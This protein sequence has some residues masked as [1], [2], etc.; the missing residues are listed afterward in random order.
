[1]SFKPELLAPAGNIESFFAAVENGAD[2]VYLG[3]K[4]FS[5]RAS[6]SNFTMSELATIVPFARKRGVRV[7]VAVNNQI[8]SGELAELITTIDRLARIHPD[9]LIVSD[10]AIFHLAR[11]HYPDLR[12]HASTLAFAHNSAGV[13]TLMGMG[14]SRVVTARELS[15][16]EIEKIY[17]NTGAELEIFIHGALCYS[18]SGLCL[19][20]SY[21]GGRSGLR[22]ECVQPCR[23]KFH[24]GSKGGFFLSCGDL[25][26]LPLV[27]RLKR[28]H[29]AA[30]KIEGRMKPASWV[31]GVVRAYRMVLDA[32][33]AEEEKRALSEAR[34]LL[35][36]NPS[37]RLS[38]GRLGNLGAA[39]ILSPSR[40]GSNG[41]W[42][43]T[44]K[45]VYENRVLLD[46]RSPVSKGDRLRPESSAG[47]EEEA[48]TVLQLFDKSGGAIEFSKAGTAA[49]LACPK[50]LKAGERLFKLGSKTEPAAAIWKRIKEQVPSAMAIK[51]APAIREIIGEYEKPEESGARAQEALTVKIDSPGDLVE[52]LQS[53][54]SSVFLRATRH[55][56]ERI[57]RQRFSTFQRK[58]LGLS[59]PPVMMEKDSEYFRAAVEWFI[60]QG[61]ALWEINNWGHF[62]L[63]GKTRGLRLVAGARLNL[64]NS[65]A[66]EQVFEMGCESAVFSLETTKV[67]LQEAAG[68]KLRSRLAVT[69]YCRPPLFTSCLV[70]PIYMDRALVSPRKEVYY[71]T[72]QAGRAEIYADRPVSWLEQ[73]PVLRALGYRRFLIDLSEGPA[74]R[75]GL[76]EI[77]RGFAS[78]RTRGGYSLFNFERRPE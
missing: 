66:F 38:C 44:V 7:Y 10:P 58:K 22:G 74:K 12:L 24:Q 72:A 17:D 62:D 26:G 27:P 43:A 31:A 76:S 36:Q 16:E 8:V 9:G 13:R 70:P 35:A 75:P 34:E 57:A 18:Y 46:V 77:L 53:S 51:S 48:F 37:R 69:V 54:A 1:M 15:L 21:R 60:N 28:A 23:L 30:L 56:L 45:G 50:P 42:I 47:R 25:C 32:E 49:Y 11:R 19:A 71:P 40:S 2:A 59:L 73:L 33:S 68:Q 63:V 64:R 55:N 41:L 67:E 6:A 78:C 61:F 39:E 29:I 4:K 5:A 65:A 52:A 3:L 14:A 20:S